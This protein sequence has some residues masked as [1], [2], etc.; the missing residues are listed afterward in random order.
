MKLLA[1]R[2]GFTTQG[3]FNIDKP[4]ELDN[5]MGAPA[6]DLNE[7]PLF[8]AELIEDGFG[9]GYLAVFL[10]REG[11]SIIIDVCAIDCANVKEANSLCPLQ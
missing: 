11:P 8:E 10:T 2:G 1:H 9:D 6:T 5:D 7:V 4:F 3:I